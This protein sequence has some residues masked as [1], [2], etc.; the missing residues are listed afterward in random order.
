MI[1]RNTQIN[2]AEIS[3]Y[4]TATN[5]GLL[6]PA[7]A[8]LLN[9]FTAGGRAA[10]DAVVTNQAQVIAYMDDYKMLTFATLAM[11]PLILVFRKPDEAPASDQ[12]MAH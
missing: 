10:L 6:N 5:P 3:R 7:V 11:F 1:V 9:P 4:A 12:A 8:H 2:H